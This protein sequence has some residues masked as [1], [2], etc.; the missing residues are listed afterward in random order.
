MSRTG[1]R[2][3]M[4]EAIKAFCSNC[5]AQYADGRTDCMKR[6][7]PLYPRMPYRKMTPQVSKWIFGTWSKKHINRATEL[8]ITDPKEYV[9][10]CLIHGKKLHLSMSD[11]IRAKHFSCMNDFYVGGNE[12]GR[13]DCGIE[14]TTE[15]E[16]REVEVEFR[17]KQ[18]NKIQRIVRTVESPGSL[19]NC[20]LYWW[21][22]YRTQEP[23]YDWM[24]DE[25]HSKH[26]RFQLALL[27]I[28]REE[29]LERLENGDVR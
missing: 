9:A 18:K 20:P 28:N 13:I 17:G 10:K 21:M 14:V 29:Y 8:G 22:P 15:E 26:H 23:C 1:L 24:F 12:P 4:T 2:P 5:R 3:S 16:N 27:K 25:A 19:R 6:D 7:C 11:M